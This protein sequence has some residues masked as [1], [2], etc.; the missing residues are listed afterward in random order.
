MPTPHAGSAPQAFA[1]FRNLALS[2]LHRW[3]HRTLTAAR[4]LRQ[5]S[6]RSLQST[7][8]NPSRTMKRPWIAGPQRP[9][10]TRYRAISSWLPQG[11]PRATRLAT[12]A[13][14]SPGIRAPAPREGR[15]RTRLGLEQTNANNISR[16]ALEPLLME[17]AGTDRTRLVRCP[18][19]V[20]LG[21]LPPRLS[22]PS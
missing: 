3:R 20:P 21:H 9:V 13:G 8:T 7:S 12:L 17:G 6:R 16:R 22:S 10:T 15:L 18:W 14:D 2:L 19:W 4:V 1:A 11:L 5:P